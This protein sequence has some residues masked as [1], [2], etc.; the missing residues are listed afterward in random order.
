MRN[1]RSQTARAVIAGVTL[2]AIVAGFLAVYCWPRAPRPTS[3][4]GGGTRLAAAHPRS[5]PSLAT[6]EA[7]PDDALR[8]A[9]DAMVYHPRDTSEW[10]GMRV[11]MSMRAFCRGA[12]SCGL[13]AACLDGQCGPCTS[14]GQCGDG[15]RCVLDHCVLASNVHCRSHRDCSADG[16][17]CVLSGYSS[18]PRGNADMRADCLVPR[19]GKGLPDDLP[20]TV[21]IPAPAP[22]VNSGALMD[23]VR[24]AAGNAEQAG[25]AH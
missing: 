21:G 1:R 16:A 25:V 3:P 8:G 24:R 12:K 10:Q 4:A 13:A 18:D 20:L 5:A 19:G 7:A 11:N 15:E 22:E 23:S 17:L 14:D 6:P 9:P 2:L